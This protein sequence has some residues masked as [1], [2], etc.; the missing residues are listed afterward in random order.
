MKP[1]A[2]ANCKNHLIQQ[3]GITPVSVKREVTKSITDLQKAIAQASTANK[4]KKKAIPETPEAIEK[5]IAEIEIEMSKAAESLDF[6]KA[7]ALRDEWFT[8][9]KML[10]S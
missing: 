6:E 4:K 5:R 8:L 1:I 10:E 7:I 9:K 2:D 3:H